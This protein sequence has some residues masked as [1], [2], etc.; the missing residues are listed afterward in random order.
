MAAVGEAFGAHVEMKRG[1]TP[2]AGLRTVNNAMIGP[3]QRSPA[4]MRRGGEHV[5]KLCSLARRQPAS[6]SSIK[7]KKLLLPVSPVVKWSEWEAQS[8][9]QVGGA[10]CY[11][12]EEIQ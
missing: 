2:T 5:G 1:C 3:A 10:S 4:E 11:Q 7:K 6:R 12:G 8:V 9:T